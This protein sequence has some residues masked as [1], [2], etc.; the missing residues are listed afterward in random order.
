MVGPTTRSRWVVRPVVDVGISEPM[1]KAKV[2]KMWVTLIGVDART[3]LNRSVP[4]MSSRAVG[5]AGV[6]L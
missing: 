6:L 5:R 2:L 4:S 3:T 1:G